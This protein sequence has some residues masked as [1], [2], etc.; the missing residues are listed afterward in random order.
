MAAAA[1]GIGAIGSLFGGLFGSGASEQAANE[2]IAALQQAQSQV[3]QYGGKATNYLE[4][5]ANLGNT[6]V[7]QLSSLLGT[8]RQGLLQP[9]NQQFTAPTAAQAEQQPGYQ[10]QL[11]QGLNALQNSA[12]GQGSLLTG[13]TLANLNN[14]AQ[15]TASQNYQN[16]FNNALTQY[17]SAYNTFQN[18]QNNTYNRLMGITGV[19]QNAAGQSANLTMNTG[20]DIAS[21]LAQQGAAAAGGTIGSA[22]AWTNALGGIANSLAGGFTLGSLNGNSN[23]GPQWAGGYNMGPP[24]APVVPGLEHTTQDLS[25]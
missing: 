10:F 5:Y 4:P 16:V 25:I 14:Y 18:N 19:G 12:A 20:Q 11:Q 22:N 21:L 3:S 23:V 1:A 17:Q 15:G 9:W 7:M 24:L 13:R 2:Y 8:P 6:G